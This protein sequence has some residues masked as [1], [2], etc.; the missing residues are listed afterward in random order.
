MFKIKKI[1]CNFQIASIV[2]SDISDITDKISIVI[3]IVQTKKEIRDGNFYG[4]YSQYLPSNGFSSDGKRFVFSTQ[5]QTEI[6][7]YVVD[8][9]NYILL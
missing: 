6:R 8:L 7:S 4:I 3:D 2:N 1:Y 5:Q 9:G